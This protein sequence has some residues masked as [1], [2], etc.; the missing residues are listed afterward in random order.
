MMV[1]STD[2]LQSRPLSEESNC[3]CNQIKEAQ[4]DVPRISIIV[5]SDCKMH[6]GQYN[7][8]V[9]KESVQNENTSVLP[10]NENS[11]RTDLRALKLP[12][13]NLF[14]KKYDNTA[15]NT[16]NCY[17][18][19]QPKELQYTEEYNQGNKASTINNVSQIRYSSSLSRW[20]RPPE[21]YYHKFHTD[22]VKTNLFPKVNTIDLRKPA[23]LRGDTAKALDVTSNE[24]PL[25]N[26]PVKKLENSTK[27]ASE[28]NKVSERTKR[29]VTVDL[30]T[31]GKAKENFTDIRKISL[32]SNLKYPVRN[33]KFE[34][35]STLPDSEFRTAENSM[36]SFK[37]RRNLIESNELVNTVCT[38]QMHK[39]VNNYEVRKVPESRETGTPFIDPF[40]TR[41]LTDML[42]QKDVDFC[43]DADCSKTNSIALNNRR[44]D[45]YCNATA[46]TH[47]MKSERDCHESECEKKC[48]TTID[49]A[50]D[51]LQNMLQS[52]R[53]L[54][55]SKETTESK[56]RSYADKE[57]RCKN[58]DCNYVDTKNEKTTSKDNYNSLNVTELMRPECMK[59]LQE[60]KKHTET[61]EEQLIIMNKSMRA[62]RK[63]NEKSVTICE[64]SKAKQQRD[65]I[66]QNPEKRNIHIQEPCSI[67]GYVKCPQSTLLKSG[68]NSRYVKEQSITIQKISEKIKKDVRDTNRNAKS[69]ISHR[70]HDSRDVKTIQCQ[71]EKSSLFHSLGTT[72]FL[73]TATSKPE[74]LNLQNYK[75]SVCYASN[76]TQTDCTPK[77]NLSVIQNKKTVSN[78][79]K[80]HPVDGKNKMIDSTSVKDESSACNEDTD[81]MLLLA[82]GVNNKYLKSR[83]KKMEFLSFRPKYIINSYV[84]CDQRSIRCRLPRRKA[85]IPIVFKLKSLRCKT[86]NCHVD[87]NRTQ[88]LEHSPNNC[89]YLVT[90]VWTQSSNTKITTATSVPSICRN[91]ENTVGNCIK[92]STE[93]REA[94]ILS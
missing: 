47:F 29:D 89:D 41:K 3:K 65:T 56:V 68:N 32:K 93:E 60:I 15:C 7:N 42:I 73:P 90:T 75:T 48:I 43:T 52:V 24:L 11:T 77:E 63:A 1:I 2:V 37:A 18:I 86:E 51:I 54:K 46:I 78:E 50:L 10:S 66:T 76:C 35:K 21:L 94:C 71:C 33:L 14:N 88:F 12:Q 6:S 8:Y 40:R 84:M 4:H 31:T 16:E 13:S 53:K 83:Y 30:E 36:K 28:S 70:I 25:K 45:E 9:Q 34:T 85:Q 69:Q 20:T 39:Y 91:D 92:K 55:R 58:R 81:T 5:R 57:I 72:N 26:F 44:K 22:T 64:N 79:L 49:S 27:V 17:D 82:K 19:S 61:L 62:R 87:V 67:D 74:M 38:N 80:D 59:M 23:M